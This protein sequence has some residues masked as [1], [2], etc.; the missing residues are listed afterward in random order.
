[1]SNAPALPDGRGTDVVSAWRAGGAGATALV[2]RDLS[3]ILD[4]AVELAGPFESA[5]LAYCRD[6]A[7]SPEDS[8]VEAER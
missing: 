3:E 8:M 5:Y 2:D 1:M 4:D 6:A 7:R